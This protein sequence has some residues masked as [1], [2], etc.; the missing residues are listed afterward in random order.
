MTKAFD[1]INNNIQ[2]LAKERNFTVDVT[3]DTV[4]VGADFPFDSLDLATLVVEMQRTLGKD[5][6][7]GGFIEFTTVAE[8]VAIFEK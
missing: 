7:D 3:P 8:L 5:P 4:L 6:F 2:N 1:I